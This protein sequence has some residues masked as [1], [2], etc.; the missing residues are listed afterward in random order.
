MQ[1]CITN[2]HY[3]RNKLWNA[4]KQRLTGQP[5]KSIQI[6]THGILHPK[7]PWSCRPYRYPNLTSCK[8][9][10]TKRTETETLAVN[11]WCATASLSIE[12]KTTIARPAPLR[13]S[14][15]TAKFNPMKR[16]ASSALKSTSSNKKT[17]RYKMNCK[18][19]QALKNNH[20]THFWT[21][22]YIA[23][24]DRLIYLLWKQQM[25]S[26]SRR[27]PASEEVYAPTAK[28]TSLA[29]LSIP[30]L[31]K[32]MIAFTFSCFMYLL[33]LLFI[34]LTTTSLYWYLFPW[35]NSKTSKRNSLPWLAYVS[36]DVIVLVKKIN[37][38]LTVTK[39]T[40]DQNWLTKRPF[41]LR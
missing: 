32:Y 5:N 3:A 29:S 24:N 6:R 14:P 8:D 36:H 4:P 25:I 38:R 35:S 9:T 34:S 13:R 10:L 18:V 40:K 19:P 23:C 15:I 33:K 28:L 30:I 41:K 7:M 27:F 31:Y 2:I 21:T 26:S 39:T 11:I 20:M 37:W 1:L 12:Q 17:A 16:S 22:H